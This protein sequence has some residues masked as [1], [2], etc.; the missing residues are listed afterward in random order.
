MSS[1]VIE[2]YLFEFLLILVFKNSMH[3]ITTTPC[4]R[5]ILNW[6][7]VGIKSIS[8]FRSLFVFQGF[9][10]CAQTKIAFC[11]H[12]QN[13]NQITPV[14]QF[15]LICKKHVRVANLNPFLHITH[16]LKLTK[17]ESLRTNDS[18]RRRKCLEVF[19][20]LS[21]YDIAVIILCRLIGSYTLIPSIETFCLLEK[22]LKNMTDL[23]WFPIWKNRW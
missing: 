5:C 17:V 10:R 7:A 22:K 15:F 12:Y 6:T 11:A 14:F 21:S 16:N 20:P 13:L 9:F 4:F 1:S 19:M 18:A 8:W 23:V 3:H 2:K